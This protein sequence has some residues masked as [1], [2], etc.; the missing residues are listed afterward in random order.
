M[1]SN[2]DLQTCGSGGIIV[3]NNIQNY[4]SATVDSQATVNED[5]SVNIQTI[6]ADISNG[7]LLAN[8]YQGIIKLQ[9]ERFNSEA[10]MDKP[11]QSWKSA[12]LEVG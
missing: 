9:G 5:G 11:K 6:V 10:R 8:Q 4:T 3:Y 7:G 2:A 1:I 12:S